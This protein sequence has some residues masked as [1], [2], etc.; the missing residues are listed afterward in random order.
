M[1]RYPLVGRVSP[2]EILGLEVLVAVAVV[3]V[4]NLVA[5]LVVRALPDHGHLGSVDLVVVREPGHHQVA[6]PGVLTQRL[7]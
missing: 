7:Q 6:L 3:D 1:R 5:G 2:P 4:Q